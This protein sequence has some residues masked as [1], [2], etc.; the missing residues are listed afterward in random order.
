MPGKGNGSDVGNPDGSVNGGERL[1]PS[2]P[3]MGGSGRDVGNA[4][5]KPDGKTG[6]NVGID[7]GAALSFDGN[8]RAGGA[9][10]PVDRAVGA[11]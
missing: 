10:A 5:G 1:P 8:V 3:G 6:G 7:G 9:P 11:P 2:K 4:D